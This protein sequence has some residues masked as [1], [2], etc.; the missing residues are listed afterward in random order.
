MKNKLMRVG[1]TCSDFKIGTSTGKLECTVIK[2]NY[3]YSDYTIETEYDLYS[4]ELYKT[5]SLIL[6]TFE[7]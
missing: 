6:K 5:M 2:V 7:I 4:D 1:L 3:I